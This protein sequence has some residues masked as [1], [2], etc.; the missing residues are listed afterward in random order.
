MTEQNGLLKSKLLVVKVH[1]RTQPLCYLQHL[2]ERHFY[3]LPGLLPIWLEDISRELYQRYIACWVSPKIGPPSSVDAFLKYTCK[4]GAER[5][6]IQDFYIQPWPIE[7]ASCWKFKALKWF[8]II[9]MQIWQKFHW[10]ASTYVLVCP[11]PQRKLPQH[12]GS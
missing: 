12:S 1:E 10:L 2:G 9:S 3:S 8:I 5:W 7:N 6:F 4:V 11:W